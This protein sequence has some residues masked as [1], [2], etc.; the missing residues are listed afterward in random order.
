[1][2]LRL[3]LNALATVADLTQRVAVL[4]THACPCPRG[5]HT[6]QPSLSLRCAVSAELSLCCGRSCHAT[7]VHGAGQWSRPTIGTATDCRQDLGYT[8]SR[9]RTGLLHRR[10]ISLLIT[11]PRLSAI[12]RC[13]CDHAAGRILGACTAPQPV[14]RAEL[15]RALPNR[16]LVGLSIQSTSAHT[17]DSIA[18]TRV[19][20]HVLHQSISHTHDPTGLTSCAACR[21]CV[22]RQRS[23]PC[24]ALF[25]SAA[26][27]PPGGVS[28]LD[29]SCVEVVNGRILL[30]RVLVVIVTCQHSTD[31]RSV[32]LR[33]RPQSMPRFAGCSHLGRKPGSTKHGTAL[34][35]TTSIRLPPSHPSARDSLLPEKQLAGSLSAHWRSSWAGTDVQAH[36][37]F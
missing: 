23:Q 2:L 6:V 33:H 31:S 15:M 5:V 21:P 22:F 27:V 4:G 1:M 10:F 17:S 9:I 11:E 12:L 35:P 24:S 19:L 30:R 14:R 29:S 34:G 8:T 13:K 25:R 36:C 20:I 26:P 18:C 16:L 32:T 37:L 7:C 28:V 3:P